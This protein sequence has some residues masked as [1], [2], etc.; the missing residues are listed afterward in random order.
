MISEYHF[1]LNGFISRVKKVTFKRREFLFP[2]VIN[3][4][5]ESRDIMISPGFTN[6]MYVDIIFKYCK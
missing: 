2:P 1:F 5:L 3:D 4:N 6:K